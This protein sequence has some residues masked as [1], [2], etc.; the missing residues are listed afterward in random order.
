MIRTVLLTTALVG[1]LMTLCSAGDPARAQQSQVER[2][3]IMVDPAPNIVAPAER[4]VALVVG[5]SNYQ[6]EKFSLAN[7]KNDAEDVAAAL[8]GLGF[9]VLTAI[10][11]TKKEFERKLADFART[12]KDADA[13]LFFY[14]GH[15]MQFQGENYLMPVDGELKDRDSIWSEMVRV[16]DVR[17]ALD[18]VDGLKVMVLDACRD[19]PLSDRIYRSA[20]GG[21]GGGPRGLARIDK[22][23]GLIVAYATAADDVAADGNGRNSPFTSA[24][25]NRMGEAGL[26]I[27]KLFR[28]VGADVAEETR[29]RQR[30][31]ITLQSYNDYYLNQNDR[32]AWEK[33]RVS[34]DDAALRDFVAKFPSSPYSAVAKDRLEHIKQSPPKTLSP[35]VVKE[36]PAVNVADDESNQMEKVCKTEEE[37]FALLQVAGAS[38]TE[39]KEGIEQL[40]EKLKCKTLRAPIEKALA[41]LSRRIPDQEPEV[42]IM[43]VDAGKDATPTVNTARPETPAV[44]KASI[45]VTGI[46]KGKSP[47]NSSLKPQNQS[48]TKGAHSKST[49]FASISPSPKTP[50]PTPQ[51][52]ESKA[53]PKLTPNLLIGATF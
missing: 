42:R 10:D 12:A 48:P 32:I 22:A 47:K 19:N 29:G 40:L 15:A 28:L 18:R 16:D 44:N 37:E 30:P 7:P 49:H 27:T 38:A 2:R 21:G 43:K 5:N 6:V 3:V 23:Q 35:P 34:D 46:E 24:L 52:P 9:D 13:A 41:D 45:H 20:A 53:S 14:A 8:S 51:K 11:A 31:E 1:T 33:I 25:L 26:E 39:R 4:R 36:P 50:V 17:R